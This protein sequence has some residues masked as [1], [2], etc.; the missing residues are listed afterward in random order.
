M[1]F[2]AI[3]PRDTSGLAV[4]DPERPLLPGWHHAAATTETGPGFG[5]CAIMEYPPPSGVAYGACGWGHRTHCHTHVDA[6][7]RA[8]VRRNTRE[9]ARTLT[10][11]RL[12]PTCACAPVALGSE[13]L[14][15]KV[16]V[17]VR[18]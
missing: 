1:R 16:R 14:V 9:R 4:I 13:V 2:A 18:V 12:A 8:R 11:V 7:A 3:L 17:R 5:R 10:R 6:R 15:G